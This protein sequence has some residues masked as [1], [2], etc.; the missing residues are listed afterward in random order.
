M[1][2]RLLPNMDYTT[3]DRGT[4]V[5]ERPFLFQH[6]NAPVHKASTIKKCFSQFGLQSTDLDP[7]RHVCDELEFICNL[8]VITCET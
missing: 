6:D 4:T 1:R 2:Q 3:E 5:G 7:T 8:R